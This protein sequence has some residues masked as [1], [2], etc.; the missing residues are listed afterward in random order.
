LLVHNLDNDMAIDRQQLLDTVKP[1]SF[2]KPPE[3]ERPSGN[4]RST[5]DILRDTFGVGENNLTNIDQVI[6]RYDP[7]KIRGSLDNYDTVPWVDTQA[8]QDFQDQQNEGGFWQS[9]IGGLIGRALVTLGR[10]LS[11]VAATAKLIDGGITNLW[12][13][14]SDLASGEGLDSFSNYFKAGKEELTD[15][16][17]RTKYLTTLNPVMFLN[18][19]VLGRALPWESIVQGEN[20]ITTSVEELDPEN[21]YQVYTFGRLFE[22]ANWLQN[23]ESHWGTK[24]WFDWDNALGTGWSIGPSTSGAL[25]LPPDLIL[26]PI[27]WL[28]GFGVTQGVAKALRSGIG[29]SGETVA[30]TV[31]RSIIEEMGE[32]VFR[33]VARRSG[34]ELAEE[35]IE[36]STRELADGV[37]GRLVEEG[38][39][40]TSEAS[41][42]QAAGRV[43]EIFEEVVE[44]LATQGGINVTA[45]GTQRLA[46]MGVAQTDNIFLNAVDATGKRVL[47]SFDDVTSTVRASAGPDDLF[48]DIVKIMDGGRV[49]EKGI[50]ALSADTA[51]VVA[52]YMHRFGLDR[53]G[54]TAA[55]HRAGWIRSYQEGQK[56]IFGT[57]AYNSLDDAARAAQD[58]IW[59]IEA[60]GLISQ[61]RTPRSG[62]L[63][64]F[65]PDNINVGK[66]HIPL[67]SAQDL[68]GS[69][70]FG[71][72]W[73]MKIPMTGEWGRKTLNN[74]RYRVGKT[75]IQHQTG[76]KFA[77][78]LPNSRA[79]ELIRLIPMQF[80]KIFADIPGSAWRR[81]TGF[82]GGTKKLLKMKVKDVKNPWGQQHARVMLQRYLQSGEMEKY[83]GTAFRQRLGLAVDEAISGADGSLSRADAEVTFF[84]ALEGD[85]EADKLLDDLGLMHLKDGL[86]S[87]LNEA[88]MMAEAQSGV[89]FLNFVDD[90]GH[91][92]ITPEFAQEL[93]NARKFNFRQGRGAPDMERSGTEHG[94]KYLTPN[95]Y[96][97]RAKDWW[98][99]LNAEQQGKFDLPDGYNWDAPWADADLPFNVRVA[100]ESAMD[101]AN[102][103]AR[104]SFGGKDFVEGQSIVAQINSIMDEAK[105]GHHMFEES[106][107]KSFSAY[108]DMLAHR[109]GQ[110]WLESQLQGAG[111]L[112]HRWLYKNGVP[113]TVERAASRRIYDNLKERQEL[114]GRLEVKLSQGVH[115]D[116]A[117]KDIIRAEIVELEAQIRQ[118]DELYLNNVKFA[119]E[120]NEFVM[121]REQAIIA[122]EMEIS[123]IEADIAARQ[124]QIDEAE[125][126]VRA[127]AGRSVQRAKQLQ[128][129]VDALKTRLNDAV[130]GTPD[131][132]FRDGL[133]YTKYMEVEDAVKNTRFIEDQLTSAFGSIQAAKNAA[134]E[135][136]EAFNQIYLHGSIEQISDGMTFWKNVAN[137]FDPERMFESMSARGLD[138]LDIMMMKDVL[139]TYDV[140]LKNL[141]D[142][143]ILEYA[144]LNNYKDLLVGAD[145]IAR[146][147]SPDQVL[148]VLELITNQEKA[149]TKVLDDLFTSMLDMT[150]Q[151]KR[152]FG[153]EF[154][155][156]IEGNQSWSEMFTVQARNSIPLD[157]PIRNVIE[158][159]G[160]LDRFLASYAE[161]ANQRIM[162]K[163]AEL[164]DNPAAST[165]IQQA[166][167]GT[168]INEEPMVLTIGDIVQMTK[169]KH[170]VAAALDADHRIFQQP[171]IQELSVVGEIFEYGSQRGQQMVGPNGKRYFVKQYPTAQRAN[172]DVLS[173]RIYRAFDA[174]API[175]YTS[176][177]DLGN[178]F[179][180][181]EWVEGTSLNQAQIN[182]TIVM[183]MNG[184]PR[185][186]NPEIIAEGARSDLLP[187]NPVAV[188]YQKGLLGDLLT[189]NW[190]A[191]GEDFSNIV[192][193]EGDGA[194][195]R[196]NQGET[197]DFLGVNDEIIDAGVTPFEYGLPRKELGGTVRALRGD[198]DASRPQ[199]VNYLL[200]GDDAG[201]EAAGFTAGLNSQKRLSGVA[202]PMLRSEGTNVE[203]L[204]RSQIR[205]INDVRASH[206]GWARFVEIYLPDATIEQRAYFTTWLEARSRALVENFGGTYIPEEQLPMRA[207]FNLGMAPDAIEKASKDGTLI[208]VIRGL[209][210]HQGLVDDA[211]FDPMLYNGRARVLPAIQN[212][213]D[214]SSTGMPIN[215]EALSPTQQ[216]EMF[217][218]PLT[219]GFHSNPVWGT[220]VGNVYLGAPRS[221][222]NLMPW[223]DEASSDFALHPMA[224]QKA[225]NVPTADVEIA[226]PNDLASIKLYGMNQE[227]HH[228][229]SK[230][231]DPALTPVQQA[232]ILDQIATEF[233]T[234]PYGAIDSW[235]GMDHLRGVQALMSLD[236]LGKAGPQL[237]SEILA[238]MTPLK[239]SAKNIFEAYDDAA[240]NLGEWY[241]YP[242]RSHIADSGIVNRALRGG[243]GSMQD[244]KYGGPDMIKY[245]NHAVRDSV[246]TMSVVEKV[247]QTPHLRAKFELGSVDNDAYQSILEWVMYKRQTMTLDEVSRLVDD[248]ADRE[249]YLRELAKPAGFDFE[250]KN[251][252][253]LRTL[254]GQNR[255]YSLAQRDARDVV[256]DFMAGL[257]IQY[258]STRS[259]KSATWGHADD[260]DAFLKRTSRSIA[261]DP[262]D[263][264]AH[265]LARLWESYHTG[266]GREGYVGTGWANNLARNPDAYA[267]P[268]NFS[269]NLTNPLAGKV[270]SVSTGESFTKSILPAWEEK[271]MDDTI[272]FMMSMNLGKESTPLRVNN[273]YL[274]SASDLGTNANQVRQSI[275]I[276]KRAQ[277]SQ[278][279]LYDD[280]LRTVDEAAEIRE[281]L[282]QDWFVKQ[283]A[284]EWTLQSQVDAY[285][286]RT[287]KGIAVEELAELELLNGEMRKAVEALNKMSPDFK[288]SG[289]ELFQAYKDVESAIQIMVK[290]D[291]DLA[292]KIV[293]ANTK[294]DL[295]AIRGN[296]FVFKD[297]AHRKATGEAIDR[298]MIQGF[299]AI[300]LQ[301]Q[302]PRSLVDSLT[303]MERNYGGGSKFLEYYDKVQN[304]WKGYAILSPGFYSRN[305]QG[306]VFMNYLAG[307]NV[308][309]YGKYVTAR[310]V[311]RL[312]NELIRKG[313]LGPK[314]QKWLNHLVKHTDP[315]EVEVARIIDSTGAAGHG[316]AGTEFRVA[317]AG[318][319]VVRV[320]GKDINLQRANPASSQFILLEKA[321]KFN[322]GQIEDILRG[323]L[324]FDDIVNK[325]G[326]ASTGMEKVW[327]FQFN[328]Q[329]LSA[330][331]RKVVKKV[332]P[333]YTWT[334]FAI[335]RVLEQ[336]FRNP[337]RMHRYVY[338]MNRMEDSLQGDMQD[339]DSVPE[340]IQTGGGIPVNMF[341]ADGQHGW[342]TLDLPPRVLMETINPMTQP[343]MSPLERV[344]AALQPIGN[345]MSPLIKAP[346]EMT[347]NRNIFQGY[348]YKGD[349]KQVP[350]PF[351]ND[352]LMQPISLITGDN[353][354]RKTPDGNW[355]MKDSYLNSM[356]SLFPPLQSLSRVMPDTKRGQ[357]NRLASVMSW[358]LGI[359][360]R[361]NSLE[362]QARQR[363][364]RL[365]E[366]RRDLQDLRDMYRIDS[367]IEGLR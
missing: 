165:E 265:L 106:I 114:I 86:R 278:D 93:R 364:Y 254:G 352:L 41:V 233:F 262:M 157:P 72:Q 71:T 135:Y 277:R 208:Y 16:Y 187:L 255:A 275:E 210:G 355:V 164:A 282:A 332:I 33:G 294:E 314:K 349:F 29:A 68:A 320:G 179:V 5:T 232:E 120:V 8:R 326:T 128:G 95:E 52:T 346:I 37:M 131:K 168:S 209:K 155:V 152:R 43:R 25:A 285:N 32:N 287:D 347:M 66:Q 65:L 94:R 300:G 125:G 258:R 263:R 75:P 289:E 30:M 27:N 357:E 181:K 150:P 223:I 190:G 100:F 361:H 261:E 362:E 69:T 111:V 343:D 239:L 171:T 38:I 280:L 141:Q 324:M 297:L 148:K 112:Q 291:A 44:D 137:D 288:G 316:Q 313:S 117:A 61:V 189:G 365:Q 243:K 256:N 172:A 212:P 240:L 130:L 1:P 358:L 45:R 299:R 126:V 85:L 55:Q 24:H 224:W 344:G 307:V 269:V 10:P 354:A 6:N 315:Y 109:T 309:S 184:E 49:V 203:D 227:A 268:Y 63:T 336:S 138:D 14:G 162:L 4:Q 20:P 306:G 105:V 113:T 231:L 260:A 308:T 188:E 76:F 15:F 12:R 246:E 175:S 144:L 166:V 216:T 82:V 197:F 159:V 273:Q 211:L 321:Q 266:L 158:D 251:F 59:R 40:I 110:V 42:K 201:E 338:A 311:V 200:F 90:F 26:D 145:G 283:R 350:F 48:T 337:A 132:H 348:S 122:K 221:T 193:R 245:V 18:T 295:N 149:V 182:D 50:N 96:K 192:I 319:G 276:L 153:N 292:T 342:L 124:L 78:G 322:V 215:F 195:V 28:G 207:A 139:E 169:F 57:E 22:D 163:Q 213:R 272:R 301:S 73:G 356:R 217:G 87:A 310:T 235:T 359:G 296:K 89:Q 257:H 367:E 351:N 36:R 51:R 70:P 360:L 252:N 180:I 249:A 237:R 154:G 281:Q 305:L 23:P 317:D 325:G 290:E 143:G 318:R 161:E 218:V 173:S 54:M 67:V 236:M 147:A 142:D 329:D 62:I 340:W 97:N 220:P 80:H 11:A 241:M 2:S 204:V 330:F 312:Q 119:E 127:A 304:V 196:V 345:M 7:S 264:E 107:S 115:A 31:T 17:D 214:V 271:A 102:T 53:N 151:L 91:R 39:D 19:V 328:Y 140:I 334:R 134:M 77:T 335:P 253:G 46:N 205:K 222:S 198:Y 270:R 226:L 9:R 177:D 238:Y 331:E 108:A 81:A 339:L 116:D 47:F 186:I 170:S 267:R 274:L 279:D 104:M 176:T 250:V 259:A 219:A 353:I 333:F 129:E 225:Q 88:H 60:E 202:Q 341:G 244:S 133:F 103:P 363:R 199:E 74:V 194:V 136:R 323:T 286:L 284:D 178:V 230:S 185:L 56:K 167:L 183:S 13:L 64:R 83:L 121:D 84:R 327:K 21:F 101:T 118:I 99:N 123:Q 228:L 58:D 3:V 234:S 303:D 156:V 206:G 229:L 302:G 247:F 34:Q 92:S 248:F 366:Q 98:N 146:A 79:D 242:M 174:E 35:S 191:A 160:D 293:A 298:V